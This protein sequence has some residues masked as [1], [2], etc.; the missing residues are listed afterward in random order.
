MEKLLILGA[1]RYA[2]VVR[3]IAEESNRFEE[4][5]FLDDYKPQAIGKLSDAASMV[6]RF[7]H[8]V[9]AIGDGELRLRLISMLSDCGFCV[10]PLVSARAFV[11][12]TASLADGCVVEPM[13]VIQ[14][15]CTVGKGCIISSGA[16]IRHDASLEDGCHVDCNAVVLSDA[17]VARGERVLCG[18]I[19]TA[20]EKKHV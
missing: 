7:T 11:S 18:E 12:R 13:A 19:Y 10:A 4:I 17:T 2:S 6:G 15:G 3:D 9:V 1:G 20:E 5:A 16:V 14:S 8:A